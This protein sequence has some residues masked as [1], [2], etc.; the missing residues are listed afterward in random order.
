MKKVVS[1]KSLLAL[2]AIVFVAW[3][4]D[5]DENDDLTARTVAEKNIVETAAGDDAL[6]SLVA[7][8]T[9]ADNNEGTNLIGTLS[10]DGPFTVLPLPTPPL[11]HYWNLLKVLIL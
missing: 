6:A 1:I 9:S 10:G 2:L 3:S 4:C 5:D 11:Q 7:T 8:L